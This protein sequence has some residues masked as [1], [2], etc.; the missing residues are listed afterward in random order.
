VRVGWERGGWEAAALLDRLLGD[1]VQGATGDA[2]GDP[3]VERCDERRK[4]EP[5]RRA[6]RDDIPEH[7]VHQGKTHVVRHER[8][9]DAV[10]AAARRLESRHLPVVVDHNL[11]PR[12]HD[13]ANSRWRGLAGH[14]GTCNDPVRVVNPAP[15]S[16]TP[17]HPV[18]TVDGFGL[19]FGCDHPGHWRD[20]FGE[21]SLSGPG[22]QEGTSDGA[23]PR[24]DPGAPTRRAVDPRQCL[25]DFQLCERID[26]VPTQFTRTSEAEQARLA[27]GLDG[28]FIQAAEFL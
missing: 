12:Q 21:D 17:F 3:H 20:A 19:A 24:Q 8:I 6:A 1:L 14:E 16:P 22:G 9:L 11:I 15:E 23:R 10:V 5:K 2:E 25:E 7:R 4:P 27:Q 26:F 13:H 28:E 18:A